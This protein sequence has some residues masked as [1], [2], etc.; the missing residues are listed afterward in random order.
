[1]NRRL[2]EEEAANYQE[3][4]ANDRRPRGIVEELRTVDQ[5]I[6]ELTLDAQRQGSRVYLQAEA[7]ISWSGRG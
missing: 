7:D 4:I 6:I 1:M 5:D 2:S 3:S